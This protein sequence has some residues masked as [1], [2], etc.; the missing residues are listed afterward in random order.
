VEETPIYHAVNELL[1]QFRVNQDTCKWS[2]QM[3]FGTDC[4]SRWA[5]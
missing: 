2:E 3:R 4:Y 1:T 5:R